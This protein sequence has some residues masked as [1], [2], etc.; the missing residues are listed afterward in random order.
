MSNSNIRR[1]ALIASLT[2]SSIEWFDFFLYGSAAALVFNKVFFSNLDP[3]TGLLLSYLTFSLTFFVR[4]LGGIF[5]AHIGDR[6]GRKKTL[7]ATLSLMGFSTVMIGLLPGYDSIGIAAPLL[8]IACRI[9]QGMGIGG[10]WGGALLL[11]YEYAPKGH[12][13][14]F[15]SVPQVGVTIGLLLA[16]T[17]MSIMT[18]LLSEENFIAWGWRIPFIASIALVGLGLWIRHG[19]DETPE[20]KEA[21]KTGNIAKTPLTETLKYHW[22]EVLQAA[23]LKVAETAPFY[24]FST[25]VVSYA[26]GI[27]YEKTTVLNAVM[28]GALV[29]SIM[30]PLCGA[31]SDRIGRPQTYAIGLIAMALFIFPYFMLLDQKTTWAIML[32]TFIIFGLIWSPI[33]ATL[34]TLF[35]EIFAARV[36]YTG[37]TLGYQLGAAL[38]GGTAPLLATWLLKEFDNSWVPIALYVILLVI[39]SLIAILSIIWRRKPASPNS[40]SQITS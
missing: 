5:F 19:L 16:S 25:F 18:Y 14:L 10:E 9:L 1:K 7:V 23:G 12:R 24:I 20:F 11:A 37:L 28:L 27:G 36:R 39:I 40:S 15:G 31:L 29:S 34:G 38:A 2:G 26:M 30:I 8:L 33:T 3:V 17:S 13:G 32:A 6:I 21:Q 22:R 35:S 4:P